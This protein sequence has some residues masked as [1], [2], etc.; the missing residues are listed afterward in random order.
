MEEYR[1]A[2][3]KMEIRKLKLEERADAIVL[4]LYVEILRR[5]LAAPG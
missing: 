1:C 3:W 5:L 2:E 4:G